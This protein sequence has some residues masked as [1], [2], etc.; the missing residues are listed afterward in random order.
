MGGE[1]A[2]NKASTSEDKKDMLYLQI[3]AAYLAGA[4]FD[5][6]LSE[7][8]KGNFKPK[9]GDAA[10]AAVDAHDTLKHKEL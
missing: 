3:G 10:Q 7:L 9:F 8:A 4:R 6:A 5:V 1:E 2:K